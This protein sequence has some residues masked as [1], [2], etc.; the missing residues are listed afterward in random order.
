M[1]RLVFG[2]SLALLGLALTA[3][4]ATADGKMS[5]PRSSAPRSSGPTHN[6]SMPATQPRIN[7]SPNSGP[8][9][10]TDPSSPRLYY[11]PETGPRIILGSG[12]TGNVLPGVPRVSGTTGTVDD[13]PVT[14]VSG[15]VGTVPD[16]D[17]PHLPKALT[18]LNKNQKDGLKK[19]GELIA[20]KK[21]DISKRKKLMPMALFELSPVQQQQLV[22]FLDPNINPGA[23]NLSET[24]KNVIQKIA[25]NDLP[26]TPEEMAIAIGV[27]G[28]PNVGMNSPTADAIGQ[29]LIDSLAANI[30]PPQPGVAPP[31][32]G[33]GI[34][35]LVNQLLGGGGQGPALAG[36]G[37]AP[38][39]VI[40][41]GANPVPADAAPGVITGPPAAGATPPVRP[42]AANGLRH[43]RRFLRVKNE[44]SQ[45]LT[46]YVQ[47]E[48]MTDKGS[49]SWFP[50]TPDKK[51]AVIFPLTAGAQ[52]EV[53]D[54]SFPINARRVRIWAAAADGTK[55]QDY[56]NQDLWLVADTEGFGRTYVAPQGETYLY[57]FRK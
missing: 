52:A 11:P 6:P 32:L 34:V 26:L 9:I 28:Q 29:G 57:V 25:N 15:N 33:Q 24:Q 31:P 23:N 35:D 3:T 12:G 50:D 17:L 46:V 56:R 8:R 19:L 16:D 47:Y 49:W 41:G 53:D 22:D 5:A 13:D 55:L 27:I 37:D 20:K 40:A 39:V 30:P 21:D 38:P 42:E 10:I 43:D 48:T 36:G 4:P 18:N 1:L 51:R 7:L 54:D 2:G 44:T 45:K 14:R